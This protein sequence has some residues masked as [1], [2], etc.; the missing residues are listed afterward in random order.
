MLNRRLI[1]TQDVFSNLTFILILLMVDTNKT[2][3]TTGT[4]QS[5]T[6]PPAD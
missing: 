3:T 5:R 6:A 1:N 2:D 4:V